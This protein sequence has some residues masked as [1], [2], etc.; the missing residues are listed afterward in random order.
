MPIAH[1]RGTANGHHRIPD[2]DR[3]QADLADARPLGFSAA[4]QYGHPPA[5]PAGPGHWPGLLARQVQQQGHHRRTRPRPLPVT[6]I[7]D[8]HG[9]LK[10]L[11]DPVGAGPLQP[12]GLTGERRLDPETGDI[13]S[14]R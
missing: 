7:Q 10:R 8:A 2:L 14:P 5:C 3:P 6:Q 11:N 1:P 13:E 4:D 9:S 12:F